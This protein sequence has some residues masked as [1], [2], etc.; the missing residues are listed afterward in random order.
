MHHMNLWKCVFTEKNGAIKGWPNEIVII[1]S[2]QYMFTFELN[3][4]VIIY[5]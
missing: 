4:T 1:K 2:K 5:V 3:E